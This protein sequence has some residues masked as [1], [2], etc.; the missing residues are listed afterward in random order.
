MVGFHAGRI[1]KHMFVGKTDD[2]N[3][4]TTLSNVSESFI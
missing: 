2:L 4:R 3:L 1:G